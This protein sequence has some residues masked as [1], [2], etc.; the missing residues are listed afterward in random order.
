[1]STR[2][3]PPHPTGTGQV[4][5]RPA[6]DVAVAASSHASKSRRRRR[7]RR[8]GIASRRAAADRGSARQN[9]RRGR[10]PSLLRA[11]PMR[12]VQV[13]PRACGPPSCPD[14]RPPNAALMAIGSPYAWANST[15]SVGVCDRIRPCRA[16]AAHRRWPRCAGPATLSPNASIASAGGPIQINPAS[17]T[18]RAN[19]GVLREEAVPRVDRIGPRASRHRQD[20]VDRQVALCRGRAPERVGLVSCADVHRVEIR[21]RVDRDARQPGV[22]ARPRDAHGDLAS[23]GD[24]NLAHPASLSCRESTD[25]SSVRPRPIGRRANRVDR[26]CSPA[27]AGG[28]GPVGCAPA[29]RRRRCHRARGVGRADPELPARLPLGAVAGLGCVRRRPACSCGGCRSGCPLSPGRWCPA[30]P[31]SSSC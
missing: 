26:G 15:T 16:P 11:R 17:T 7:E 31:W 24:E 20:L 25:L 3:R 8:R 13:S 10:T 30:S 22:P 14:R 29:L 21:L 19:D 1:M 5:P 23:V 6:S 28:R 27:G 18:A 2:S 4:P 12:I 9:T